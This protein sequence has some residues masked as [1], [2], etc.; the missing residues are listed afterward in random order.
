[1]FA[2]YY[3]NVLIDISFK[4]HNILIKLGYKEYKSST[5]YNKEKQQKNYFLLCT[6]QHYII[7]IIFKSTL[8]WLDTNKAECTV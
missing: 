3:E 5:Q 6:L 1:M 7:L 2:P 8:T 4:L